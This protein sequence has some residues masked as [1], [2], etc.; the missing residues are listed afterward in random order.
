[1]GASV[2]CIKHK[3]VFEIKK[4]HWSAFGVSL[5]EY[6]EPEKTENLREKWANEHIRYKG[7]L[8]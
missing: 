5:R 6:I 2:C 7:N 8:Y 3:L 4:A 1:M